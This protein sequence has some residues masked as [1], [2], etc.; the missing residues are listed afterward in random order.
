MTP[1]QIGEAQKLTREWSAAF[2]KR[3]RPALK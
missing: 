2:A 3:G 1:E